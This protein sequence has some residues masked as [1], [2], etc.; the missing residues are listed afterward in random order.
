MH[1]CLLRRYLC[2]FTLLIAAMFV[3]AGCGK[4]SG[5]SSG[6]LALLG[7]GGPDVL[8]APENVTASNGSFTDKVTVTWDAVAGAT[9]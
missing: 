1:S 8:Q 9:Y 6:L 5:G 4:T 2:V 3:F 7:G